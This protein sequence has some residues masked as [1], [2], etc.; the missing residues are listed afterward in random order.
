[1]PP[2]GYAETAVRLRVDAAHLRRLARNFPDDE[3]AV[4]LRQLA[5]EM[6]AQALVLLE[7]AEDSGC[8]P[9]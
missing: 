3:A 6:D 8:R 5:A 2:S 1:L 7:T 4:H 9:V